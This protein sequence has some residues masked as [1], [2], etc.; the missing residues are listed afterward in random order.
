MNGIT[1]G[2]KFPIPRCADSIEDLSDSCGSFSIIS[3]DTWSGYHQIRYR[4]SDQEKLALFTPNGTKKTFEVIPFGPKNAQT[5]YTTMMQY[6]RKEWLL[7]FVDTNY[8]IP[9]DTV[10]VAIICNDRIFH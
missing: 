6:L 8:I 1:F 7:V 10:P 2:F 3:L 4:R 5:F 9:F